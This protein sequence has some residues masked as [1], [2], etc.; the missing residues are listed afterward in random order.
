M[1]SK[2]KM[3]KHVDEMNDFI[4]LTDNIKVILNN[5]NGSK[6]NSNELYDLVYCKK[7][8]QS[9]IS[10]ETVNEDIKNDAKDI[11]DRID[12]MLS[13][14]NDSEYLEMMHR[15]G[16]SNIRELNKAKYDDKNKFKGLKDK[17]K[18]HTVFQ[19][20]TQLLM[21]NSGV[22]FALITAIMF[23]TMTDSVTSFVNFITSSGTASEGMKSGLCTV[24]SILLTIAMMILSI[25]LVMDMMYTMFP[26]FKYTI[27]SNEN[28]R[29]SLVSSAALQAVRESEIG[30]DEYDSVDTNNRLKTSEALLNNLEVD[31]KERLDSLSSG[32]NEHINYDDTISIATCSLSDDEL[33]QSLEEIKKINKRMKSKNKRE[34]LDAH[35]DAEIYFETI[36]EKLNE[37]GEAV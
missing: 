23:I 34:A 37:T 12:V 24:L 19:S 36:G 22:K 28:N 30:T 1:D 18:R 6:L 29:T 20:A 14:L 7:K 4:K 10:E 33:K 21:F 16:K 8:L 25:T 17:K 27:D 3:S 2:T 13:A 35:V 32:K 5:S 26:A 15:E 9:M 11:A 31:I